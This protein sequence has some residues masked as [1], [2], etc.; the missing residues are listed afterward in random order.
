MSLSHGCWRRVRAAGLI[1][2]IGMGLLSILASGGPRYAVRPDSSETMVANDRF[3]AR[4]IPTCNG[5]CN[6]FTLTIENKSNKDM[7][8]DWNK[9]LYIAQ[10]STS[11]GFMFEGIVYAQRNAPKPPDIVFKKATFRKTIYPTNLVAF[12]SGRYGGWRH[13]EMP[14][15]LN[16][17]YLTVR[18]GSEEINEKLTTNLV[19]VQISQ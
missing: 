8:V 14:Q 10:G 7:E 13:E 3:V 12:S 4:L 16:G 15:G 2:T 1:L 9:T 17:V 5:G 19:A 6:A 18:I 11:G